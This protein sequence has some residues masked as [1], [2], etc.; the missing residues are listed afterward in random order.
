MSRTGYPTFSIG[1]PSSAGRRVRSG[2]GIWHQSHNLFD[3]LHIC[4]EAKYVTPV[5]RSRMWGFT[6]AGYARGEPE[7][8]Q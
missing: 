6:A 5:G 8:I 7:G 2:C 1:C 3:L 4:N